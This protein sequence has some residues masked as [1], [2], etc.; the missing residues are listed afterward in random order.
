MTRRTH[1]YDA[2]SNKWL[3]KRQKLVLRRAGATDDNLRG[4]NH[5]KFIDENIENPDV[6]EANK[7][8]Y[9]L[10]DRANK[11]SDYAAAAQSWGG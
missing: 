9:I 4:W 10:E 8:E 1:G 6:D 2:M 11:H 7:I 3:R 5:L